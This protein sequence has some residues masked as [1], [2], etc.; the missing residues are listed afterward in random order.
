MEKT[1]EIKASTMADLAI[2]AWRLAKLKP[3]NA[4]ERMMLNKFLKH[5]K[6]LLEESEIKLIDMTGKPFSPGM[7][8]E[9]IHTENSSLTMPAEEII[10]ETISPSII[11]EG[12]LFRPGQVITKKIA[13]GGGQGESNQ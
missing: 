4:K 6:L 9:V 11:I 3:K 5:V 7:S 12:N 2:E 8:V 13:R 1:I 10:S